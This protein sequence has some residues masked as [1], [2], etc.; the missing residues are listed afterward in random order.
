MDD[1]LQKLKKRI[2]N[3]P[4]NSAI[5]RQLGCGLDTEKDLQELLN[6]LQEIRMW[7][8]AQ[9]VTGFIYNDD[10]H[11]FWTSFKDDIVEFMTDY[12][13]S[14]SLEM[15]VD[16]VGLSSMIGCDATAVNFYVYMFVEDRVNYILDSIEDPEF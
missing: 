6:Q 12:I 2:E 16:Q 11:Q 15:V 7:G 8:L 3:D 9:G 10:N 4:V 5:A 1:K 14:M 13:N